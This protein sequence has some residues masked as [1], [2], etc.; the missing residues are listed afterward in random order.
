MSKHIVKRLEGSEY[1]MARRLASMSYRPIIFRP[2]S[3]V[4]AKSSGG[5]YHLKRGCASANVCCFA[6]T[7]FVCLFFFFVVVVFIYLFYFYLFIYFILFFFLFF[8]F[9]SIF[10]TD[11]LCFET[12][13]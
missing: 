6:C 10:K 4:C 7:G 12:D 11:F 9:I 13:V 5:C 1:E 8:F 2:V 3:A